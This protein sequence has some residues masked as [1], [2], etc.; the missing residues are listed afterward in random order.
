MKIVCKLLILAFAF[1]SFA[2]F[3]IHCH[4]QPRPPA[5]PSYRIERIGCT[6]DGNKLFGEAFIPVAPGKH[7]AVIMSHGYGS[8]NT[9][10]YE[11]ASTLAKKGYVC[12]CYDFAGGS[13][14][15]RSEGR[16]QD[17][18]IFTQRQNL[19]DVLDMVRDWKF[20]DRKNIFLMGVSQGGC[21]SAI[22]A[23]SVKKKINAILLIYPAL[24]IPDDGLAKYPTL[25][26]VPEEVDFMRMTIGRP[27]YERF[28]DG[29]D[30]YKE[31]AGYQGPVLLL[32]GTEDTLVKPEYSAR[33]SNVYRNCE[34]H[35]LFGAGHGFR[36]PEQKTL[37][38]D[39]VEDFLERHKK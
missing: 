33:A 16:T 3:S 6:S 22:T 21:V 36:N 37:Y 20:V 34:L 15:S 35:L 25:A 29:Y 11:I 31:I 32:H 1:G 27:Y 39:Y 17:G 26:D 28:Y 14:R 8:T 23:P 19:I 10:F 9:G 24:C 38:F 12:Y 2:R 30:I 4:A 5:D 7:P 13:P 18:S